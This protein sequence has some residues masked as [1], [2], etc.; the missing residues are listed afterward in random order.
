MLPRTGKKRSSRGANDGV[1]LHLPSGQIAELSRRRRAE[2]VP[3]EPPTA[4]DPRATPLV[5]AAAF[6]VEGPLAVSSEAGQPLVVDTLSLEDFHVLRTV[7]IALA[8][9]DETSSIVLSKQVPLGP[10]LD[11]ELSDDELDEPFQFDKE[12]DLL[13]RPTGPGTS[14][15]AP[16]VGLAPLTVAEARPLWAVLAGHEGAAG[17]RRRVAR[18]LGIRSFDGEKVGPRVWRT[19]QR[20]DDDTW[21]ALL[22][23]FEAAHYSPRIDAHVRCP[24]CEAENTYRAPRIREFP[25]VDDDRAV[26]LDEPDA[27]GF[28]SPDA[29]L[30]AMEEFGKKLYEDAGVASV[31]LFLELAVPHV[32][33][34]GTPL[35]GSYTPPLED[36]LGAPLPGEIRLYYRTF[37]K[38]WTDA[39]P[40]DVDDEIRETIEHELAHHLSFLRGYDQTDEEERAAIVRERERI[41]GKQ[42]LAR[43]ESATREGGL[44]RSWPL[45][46]IAVL[47]LWFGY[48]SWRG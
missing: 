13:I 17:D 29:F 33:D 44:P 10:I 41:V 45:W 11:G 8:N 48:L 24:H 1:R 12:H 7:A 34:G 3:S 9:C 30:A 42:A 46:V 18:H 16:R 27:A 2:L 19:I 28:P 36:D 15:S 39:G 47:L 25:E 14:T 37:K 40:Y 32:D 38:R 43:D 21:D 31:P 6:G 4:F 23:L 5:H 20:M 22:D 26:S 35:L